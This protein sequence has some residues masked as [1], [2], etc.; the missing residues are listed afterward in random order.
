M[1]KYILTYRIVS[2]NEL[3]YIQ[4][5]TFNSDKKSDLIDIANK[6]NKSF[7][8]LGFNGGIS[9]KDGIDDISVYIT[10]FGDD[11]YHLMSYLYINETKLNANELVRMVDDVLF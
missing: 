7:F 6:I 1:K 3:I 8:E 10:L 11:E 5:E 9:S 2:S 4:P